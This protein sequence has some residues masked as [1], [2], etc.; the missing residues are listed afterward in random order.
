MS[1]ADFL[2]GVRTHWAQPVVSEVREVGKDARRQALM[3]K[4][5][6]V[7]RLLADPRYA[8]PL[9]LEKHGAKIFSQFDE[10][11]I[12]R[13][14]FKRIGETDRRFVE[15]GVGTG[16]EN[17]TVA[18][19]LYG[20]RGLWIEGS[21][22]SARIIR[23]RFKDVI[24]SGR[25][26]LTEAFITKDNINQL[27]GDWGQGE[28]DLLSIDIDGN[29][30]FVWQAID[31]V[32]PRV[33]VAEYNGKF[34]PDLAVTQTY[35]PDHRYDYSDYYGASLAALERLGRQKGY[36]L[37]GCNIAGVNAFFVR[38][39]LVKGKFQAPFTAENHYQPARYY[40]WQLYLAGHAFKPG[41]G[42]FSRVTE[43][44]AVEDIA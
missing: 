3:T 2:R 27:I 26:T 24:G 6:H 34:P 17:N 35:N 29:D 43:S 41:W 8:D 13:E 19:L 22:H 16:I 5:E 42:A 36:A 37:V 33:I 38:E 12:I 31:V 25:L 21:P 11:G 15:F 1:L 14:I 7:E 44:G 28:I 4:V 23:E 39:D 10:D 18:L 32:R 20:W 40:L 30:Y 9:R